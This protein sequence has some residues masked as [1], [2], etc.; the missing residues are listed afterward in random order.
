MKRTITTLLLSM[1]V[2]LGNC[3]VGCI[4]PGYAGEKSRVNNVIRFGL[5]KAVEFGA[6]MRGKAKLI[7]SGTTEI[8]DLE[9]EQSPATVMRDG[10]AP[11]QDSF[12]RSII[13]PNIEL[14]RVY[15]QNAGIVL[16]GINDIAKTVMPT[17]DNYLAGRTSVALAKQ[18]TKQMQSE[19]I[20]GIAGGLL[21]PD[22]IANTVQTLPADVTKEVLSDPVV[23]AKLA[24]LQAQMDE[25][26]NPP[27]ASQPADAQAAE[28]KKQIDD[29]KAR[30][31]AVESKAAASAVKPKDD[32]PPTE[33]D[34]SHGPSARAVKKPKPVD[35]SNRKVVLWIFKYL[36]IA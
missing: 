32:A 24:Q 27:P 6:E 35:L 14:N 23:I 36:P 31:D 29:L 25:L 2:L 8:Q 20:T 3:V 7:K 9:F 17:V 33:G 34:E 13:V 26:L 1:L 12:G 30:L 15:G 21:K 19:M 5:F 28:Y 10:W 11:A 4:N 18:Q 16:S 22:E